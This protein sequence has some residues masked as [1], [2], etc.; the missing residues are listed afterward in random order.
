MLF[1]PYPQVYNFN[2][3]A[4]NLTPAYKH[5]G[6]WT[7]WDGKLA[8]EMQYKIST[9]IAAKADLQEIWKSRESS[10]AQRVNAVRA[11]LESRL[12]F[13]AS[14]WFEAT[15]ADIVRLNHAWAS[16]ARTVV[17]AWH[18]GKPVGSNQSVLQACGLPDAETVVR[19][20]RLALA[21]KAIDLGG[22]FL[23]GLLAT[24]PTWQNCF[25]SDAAWLQSHVEKL[26]YAPSP[27]VDVG[28]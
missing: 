14:V 27:F 4:I 17:G 6:S 7:Q 5:L 8:K 24:T 10:V 12:F 18:E 21:R 9:M 11:F 15:S 26:A 2:D 25:K 3:Y 20:A 19:R 22:P 28:F 16:I 13:N 1:G 23:R